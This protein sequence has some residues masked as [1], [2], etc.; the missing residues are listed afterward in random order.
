VYGAFVEARLPGGVYLMD[1]V[2]AELDA[3][4]FRRSSWSCSFPWLAA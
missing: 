3:F 1:Q 2:R 4:V